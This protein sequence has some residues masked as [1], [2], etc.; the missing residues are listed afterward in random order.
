MTSEH[1]WSGLIRHDFWRSVFESV[2]SSRFLTRIYELAESLRSRVSGK[3]RESVFTIQ[4]HR[5]Y[6]RFPMKLSSVAIL[7]LRS[8]T[9]NSTPTRGRQPIMPN[10]FHAF[11][12]IANNAA[13]EAS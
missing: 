12:S 2:I 7:A 11:L 3:K 1:G 9:S 4:L 6:A 8:L 10:E 5:V 13:E